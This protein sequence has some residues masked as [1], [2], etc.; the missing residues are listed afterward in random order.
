M[1]N[2]ITHFTHPEHQLL[3]ISKPKNFWCDLCK[4]FGTG[5]RYR[6]DEC[7]FD[8]HESCTTYPETLS[9]FAHPWHSLELTD[10]S[11]STNDPSICCDLCCEP[12]KGFYYKC[13]PCGFNLH[14][15]C[16]LSPKIVRTRFHPDHFLTLVPTTGSCSA[17][18]K[19]L[20]VWTYR[21]GMC[22]VNLHYNCLFSSSGKE[23]DEGIE[24]SRKTQKPAMVS[25]K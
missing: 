3:L 18:N 24:A 11:A 22:S 12:L 8:L 13:I 5:L 9:F 16:S 4:T 10:H 20:T 14:P 19:N 17:C 23:D 6:C 25:R 15:S 1:A 7:D 21:C 2:T